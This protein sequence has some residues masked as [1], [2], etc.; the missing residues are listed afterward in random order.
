M[1]IFFAVHYLENIVLRGVLLEGQ[2]V[3]GLQ[4]FLDRR[5]DGAQHLSTYFTPKNEHKL[6]FKILTLLSLKLQ[7][8]ELITV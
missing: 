2:G 5:I 1:T 8:I 7:F 4:M 3:T 6:Q